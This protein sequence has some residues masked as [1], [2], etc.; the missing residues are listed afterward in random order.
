MDTPFPVDI[1]N[2]TIDKEAELSHLQKLPENDEKAFRIGHNE[3]YFK[4][5]NHDIIKNLVQK[6]IED[7]LKPVEDN[8]F[9]KSYISKIKD[10]LNI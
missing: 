3:V 5:F 1:T 2:S 10:F 6:N 7:I 9:K 4:N 8:K